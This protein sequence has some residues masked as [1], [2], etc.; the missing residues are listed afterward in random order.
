MSYPLL[1]TNR[2]LLAVILLAG[3][4][5]CIVAQSSEKLNNVL[6]DSDVHV[7]KFVD[8]EYPS[9][10]RDRGV[11]SEG[12]VVVRAK[13]DKKGRVSDAE[14]ISGSELLISDSLANIKKWQFEPNASR[15]AVVVYNFRLAHGVCKTASSLF[16]LEKSYL[17]NITGCFPIPAES[18]KLAKTQESGQA[19]VNDRDINVVDFE[20]I[21]Y[22]P[23]AA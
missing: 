12:A 10:A 18:T 20:D 1:L 17:A 13:L 2:P 21:R 16:A 6:G 3:I 5:S 11:G 15:T 8:L 19:L 9:A 7:T 14:A 22:P 23:L 4:P